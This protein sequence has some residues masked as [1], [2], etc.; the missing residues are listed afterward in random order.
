MCYGYLL[1][2][3]IMGME[4]N[5]SNEDDLKSHAKLKNLFDLNELPKS[6]DSYEI[7]SESFEKSID[8]T[9]TGKNSLDVIEIVEESDIESE[10]EGRKPVIRRMKQTWHEK[11][12][13]ENTKVVDSRECVSSTSGVFDNDNLHDLNETIEEEVRRSLSREREREAVKREVMHVLKMC[14]N[15]I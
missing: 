7:D 9:E 4:S 12:A 6:F 5:N 1:Y 15:G 13:E 3:H 11:D 8:A 10:E 2:S 14:F